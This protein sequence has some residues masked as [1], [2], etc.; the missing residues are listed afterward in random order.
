[1][2]E[3]SS[4]PPHSLPFSLFPVFFLCHSPA[5]AYALFFFHSIKWLLLCSWH[6]L[7]AI[8][9]KT[10]QN[11]CS[12]ALME[13]SEEFGRQTWNQLKKKKKST[14]KKYAKFCEEKEHSS[15][16]ENKTGI[17]SRFC[18]QRKP[19]WV[20]SSKAA[21]KEYMKGSQMKK[22][23]LFLKNYLFIYFCLCWV[24]LAFVWA[25]SSCSSRA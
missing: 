3:I 19:L 4:L 7:D 21:V 24:F 25:F 6:C 1:M 10:E 20:S 12:L 13:I 8:K 15:L 5:F 14:T 9:W 22:L 23:G 11:R 16:N 2:A 18:N 17:C